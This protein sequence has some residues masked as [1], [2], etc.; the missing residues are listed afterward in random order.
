MIIKTQMTIECEG[1]LLQVEKHGKGPNL[2]I[3]GSVNYYKKVIPS[4]LHKYFTCI[5]LDHRGFA[6]KCSSSQLDKAIDLDII[7]ADI[8]SICN[9]HNIKK[10]SV[11]G[12]SGHAYMAIH[13]AGHT[14]IEVDKLIVVGAAPSLSSKMQEK[15]FA[16]WSK[17]ASE[18]RQR[19]LENS[20]AMLESDI[21]NEPERKFAHICRRLGPMRW[22]NPNFDELGLWCGVETNIVLLD[23]LWGEVFRDIDLTRISS[24]L[25][26]TVINGELD[27]S[28]APLNT[29]LSIEFAFKSLE[30]I[31]LNGVSHTPMLECPEKFVDMMVNIQGRC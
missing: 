13:F 28:I 6:A 22:A 12:H 18:E 19:L 7:S 4:L 11:L 23:K 25:N 26:V 15:Q 10:T 5:Y 17:N 1:Y 2:L 9:H 30:L 20:M 14:K 29:W 27:F 8:E 24:N 3:I 21:A 16:Y 31:E